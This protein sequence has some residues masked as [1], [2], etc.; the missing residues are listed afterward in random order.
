MCVVE[1]HIFIYCVCNNKMK[2]KVAVTNIAYLLG[3][4]DSV[5]PFTGTRLYIC[6]SIG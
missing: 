1:N 4:P 2:T 3:N 5:K 6:V